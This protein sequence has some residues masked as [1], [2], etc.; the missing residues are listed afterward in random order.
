MPLA[1]STLLTV[2]LGD[3]L[4]DPHVGVD[5]EWRRGGTGAPVPVRV[6]RSSPDRVTA[7]FGDRRSAIGHTAVI[8]ATDV[9]TA[10][11]ADVPDLAA[12]DSFA[13]G[14]DTLVITHAERDA[15]GVAWRVFCRREP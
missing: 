11:V 13:L 2:A 10:A 7:A 12:G 5:A 9:L 1:P 3:I 6:V 14:P 8:Q 4:A 15:L